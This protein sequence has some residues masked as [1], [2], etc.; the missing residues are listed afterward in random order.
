MSIKVALYRGRQSGRLGPRLL[1]WWQRC[2]YSHCAIVWSIDPAA[3]GMHI[4]D[5][6]LRLGV[7]SRWVRWEPALWDL[8]EI[9]G[10]R[11]ECAAWVLQHE[12][13]GYDWLGLAGFLW[14]RIK[15][16][17]MAWWCSELVM[18]AAVRMPDPWRWDV[19]HLACYLRRHGR[20]VN[21]EAL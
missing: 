10:D 3:G 9:D 13:Q 6:S 14:R 5:A 2:D 8:W 21:A 7:R 15:G 12:G 17:S 4:S 16:I 19:A 18:A 11:A 1:A 20:R